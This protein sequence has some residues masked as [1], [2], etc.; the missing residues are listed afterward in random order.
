MK[1]PRKVLQSYLNH[2][3]GKVRSCADWALEHSGWRVLRVGQARNYKYARLEVEALRNN[4]MSKEDRLRVRSE[5]L[6]AGA[7]Y[8][9]L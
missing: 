5:T 9:L 3:D 4:L 1:A 2:P 6:Y 7:F 8:G